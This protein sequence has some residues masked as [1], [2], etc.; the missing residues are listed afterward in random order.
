MAKVIAII[1]SDLHA[2]IW[3]QHNDDGRRNIVV[4]KVLKKVSNLCLE[5]NVPAIF[6]G[7]WFHGYDE[8]PVEAMIDSFVAYKEYFE[9][10]KILHF[11]ISGNHDYIG[12]NSKKNPSKS[13]LEAFSSI[14]NTFKLLDYKVGEARGIT[15][16]GIPYNNGNVDLEK[17]LKKYHTRENKAG[18]KRVLL[19]HTDWPG[20]K[21]TSNYEIGSYDNISPKIEKY[22]KSYDLILCGHIHKH[23]ELN[24][25]VM[26]GAPNQQRVSDIGNKMGVL[27][28]Y[29][30]L[31]IEQVE[32][33]GIPKFVEYTGY[34]PVGTDMYIKIDE[35][36]V[37]EK[38]SSIAE[39]ST[40][41]NPK[42]VG[43]AYLKHKKI[44]SKSKKKILLELL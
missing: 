5:H 25:L 11:A 15:L 42:K 2:H 9:N 29:D 41:S 10:P 36:E 22:L 40:I 30:D 18:Y 34:K 44:K 31:S 21:D 12:K 43:K 14:F 39:Y 33:K 6:T 17:Q 7:D 3:K 13:A 23:Q 37:E 35:K 27:K 16:F 38:E 19:L 24:H 28:L 4:S 26:V 32:I 8:V 1:Y 20:A